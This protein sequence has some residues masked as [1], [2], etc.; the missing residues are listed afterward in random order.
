MSVPIL[1]IPESAFDPTMYG[2][3]PLRSKSQLLIY[4]M[5]LTNR[6]SF[7]LVLIYLIGYFAIRPLMETNIARRLEYLDAVRGKLRDFYL[8]AITKVQHIPI[9]A[10]KRNGKL[11]ADEIVQTNESKED[12][13]KLSQDKL[14]KSL[15]K[16]SIL[17]NEGVKSYST[18]Q[19]SNYSSINYAIKDFQNKSDLVYFNQSELFVLDNDATPL[20]SGTTIRKKDIA[21]E[22]KN[23]IRSIKGLYM[24]GHA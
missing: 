12:N 13:D 6:S 2:G 8:R 19:L 22:T 23:E 14:C 24:S 20:V 9:V 5:K 16:L 10:I 11:Y 21:V 17:L 3:N 4:L 18:T 15:H 7:A 1:T